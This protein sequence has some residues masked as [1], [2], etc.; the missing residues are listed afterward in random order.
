MTSSMIGVTFW[1]LRKAVNLFVFDQW[2]MA[3]YYYGII[4]WRDAWRDGDIDVACDGGVNDG[5]A[6]V[7]TWR[8]R[9]H[10]GKSDVTR[11]M[12][13]RGVAAQSLST[14]K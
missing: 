10:S 6:G 12:F 5:V 3:A 1:A 14:P 11:G 8:G 7:L 13:W 4:Q 2:N 9:R